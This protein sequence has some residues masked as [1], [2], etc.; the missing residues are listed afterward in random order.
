MK[1]FHTQLLSVLLLMSVAIGGLS[2]KK[3]SEPDKP[4]I[5]KF[6]VDA[7]DTAILL[8]DHI[9]FTPTVSTDEEVVYE[10]SI[11]GKKV[12]NT[13]DYDF[14]S[15]EPGLF[16]L[17]FTVRNQSGIDSR[18]LIISV[19]RYMNGAYIVNEGWFGHDNGSVNYYNFTTN[20]IETNVFSKNNQNQTLGVTSQYGA[21][22]DGNLYF[23]S[24]QGRRLV[25]A[26]TLGLTEIGALEDIGGGDGRAF[27]GIDDKKGVITTTDGAFQLNLKPLSLGGVIEAT[28]GVQCGGVIASD[29]HLFVVNQDEGLQI[30]ST[31]DMKLVNTIE[32]VSV[33]FAK[34]K[35]GNI[36]AA[37]NNKLIKINPK[38]LAIETVDLPSGVVIN[39]SWGAWNAGSLCAA[40][41]ENALYFTKSGAWGGGNGIYKYVVGDIASLNQVFA[42]GVADDAFYGA[43]IRV[44][45]TTGD[46]VA[47]FCRD[48]WGDS[49]ADNRLVVFDGKSGKEKSRLQFE[50]YWFPAM[51]FFE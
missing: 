20:T 17:I 14:S 9:T 2:C 49:Y 23:V 46:V 45:P 25:Q 38:T 8:A 43:S 50:Y 32:N 1:R 41:D 51:V 11:D 37:A 5:T 29:G 44:N 3:Q 28:K 42:Q 33:G 13:K 35:D 19:H 26:E 15:Q 48:G 18:E 27:C 4:L 31:S 6:G 7:T 30:F 12:N 10:W 36:W 22:W 16:K 24:K 34:T 40:T 39:S 47:T 21:S